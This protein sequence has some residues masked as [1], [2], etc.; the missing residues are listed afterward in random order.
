MTLEKKNPVAFPQVEVKGKVVRVLTHQT[1]NGHIY[2]HV[3]NLAA[4]D[5]HGY[6]PGIAIKSRAQIG[7][8]DEIVTVVATCNRRGYKT[9][10]GQQRYT[11]EFWHGE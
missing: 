10:D 9:S 8:V 3:I 1:R 5:P 11:H 6:P 7:N 2:E 4:T